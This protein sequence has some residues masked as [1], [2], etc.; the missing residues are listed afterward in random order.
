M[1]LQWSYVFLALS[2]WYLD[3][4]FVKLFNASVLHLLHF[5]HIRA[6]RFLKL[7]ALYCFKP[8]F[9]CRLRKTCLQIDRQMSSQVKSKISYR[10]ARKMYSDESSRLKPIQVYLSFI[11]RMSLCNN[12]LVLVEQISKSAGTQQTCD[13]MK[14]SLLCQEISVLTSS[15][16]SNDI[17][18][19]Q[20]VCWE[21]IGV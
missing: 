15:Q 12:D 11:S 1:H 13:A 16:C 20:H 5:V 8:V 7:Y 18:P 6:M 19:A 17:T 10:N 4:S 9:F 2:H 21:K 14:Q 3:N